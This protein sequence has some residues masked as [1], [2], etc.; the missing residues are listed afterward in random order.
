VTQAGDEHSVGLVQPAIARFDEPLPLACGRA[1]PAYEL[2]YETYGVLNEQR[3]NAVL[4]CHA[5]SGNHHAAGY[6]STADKKPGW[7]D[8]CIGPGKPIDTDRF[9]VVSLNNLGGCHGSTGP[10]SIN[11]ETGEVWGPDFPPLRARDWV[12]SQARLADYLGID[13]WAAVIGGSL[14]GMQAMRW[15]LE[16]PERIKHCV[17][18]AAAMKLSAQNLAFNE[19]ARQAILSDPAFAGGH[20]LE[21]GTLPA[22]GLALARMVGHIT[23]L[24]DHAMAN[25][26]GRDLRSGSLEQGNDE[27]VEFQVQSYLRYQGSQFSGNFDANT[28]MLMTRALDYFDLAREYGNDAVAAFRHASCGFLVISFSTDW[29]FSPERSREIVDALIAADRP[30]TYAEIEADEGHDAFLLPIPRYMKLFSAYMRRV[31]VAP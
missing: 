8:E 9:Y 10:S 15:S 11:P 17:V 12:N 2:V 14:G 3:S 19:V 29:R 27:N 6:H 1:L 16:Y 23:Y 7:W 21:Q 22:Q 25:K 26:F 28:Y 18:I 13:C 4:I 5:L 30:V 24:S 31:G 20:Y